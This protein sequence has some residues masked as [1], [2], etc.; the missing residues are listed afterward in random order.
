MFCVTFKEYE[1]NI[2]YPAFQ[3]DDKKGTVKPI[4]KEVL[5]KLKGKY[6]DWDLLFW[7]NTY[8]D[9]LECKP[10]VA[11]DIPE[12]RELLLDIADN[13]HEHYI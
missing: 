4:I 2:G 13:E 3:F 8:D 9:D 10:L 12:L 6:S 5:D 11:I 7:F 1:A